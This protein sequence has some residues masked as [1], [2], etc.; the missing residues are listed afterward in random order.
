ML[1]MSPKALFSSFT[2]HHFTMQSIL[3]E[4]SLSTCAR[5]VSQ[6][7]ETVRALESSHANTFSPCHHVDRSPGSVPREEVGERP[8]GKAAAKPKKR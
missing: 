2:G 4:S 3:K 1:L 8:K 6:R 5:A 7:L